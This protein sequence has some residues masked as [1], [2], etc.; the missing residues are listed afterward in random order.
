M[1]TPL[2]SRQ[3]AS[4][5]EDDARF[6]RSWLERPLLTGAVTPSGRQLARAMAAY[7]DPSAGGPVVELG[8]GTGPVTSALIERGVPP[9]NLVLVEFNP[10]FVALLAERFPGVTVVRGNAYEVRSTLRDRL[11]APPTAIVSS[12]PL[13]TKPTAARV[14]LL[15]DCLALAGPG[16]CFVQFTYGLAPPIP[17]EAIGDIRIA[18]SPRIWWNFPPARVWVYR[19]EPR[20]SAAPK[21]GA[22]PRGAG[23]SR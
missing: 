16:A 19:R 20:L 4:H 5:L 6:L 13:L 22:R 7:V 9:E 12:L 3:S 8:P 15:E 11:A 23:R 2:S 1:G 21:Q 17:R 14:A 18:G 10:D